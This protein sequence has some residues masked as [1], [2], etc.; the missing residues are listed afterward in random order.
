MASDDLDR[1]VV[2]RLVQ[3][4]TKPLPPAAPKPPAI[5]A[6]A[7][8]APERHVHR[9]STWTSA[10]ILMPVRNTP[11]PRRTLG[12]TFRLPD[13]PTFNLPSFRLPSFRLPSIGLP[14]LQLPMFRLP[15]LTE[16]TRRLLIVR[17]WVTLGTVLS[18]S[19]PFWPY[20]KT[21]LLGLLLYLFALGVVA[22]AGI[23]SAKLSWDVRLGG[24]HTVSLGIVLWAIVLVAETVPP[25]SDAF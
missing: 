19:M 24:A 18:L 9:V 10:R 13:L 6:A 1:Q 12:S 16:D 8:P 2:D 7:Q 3:G 22:L 4:L 20:Q 14:A 21:Y 15:A 23:W 11:G 25:V 17:G 5:Q